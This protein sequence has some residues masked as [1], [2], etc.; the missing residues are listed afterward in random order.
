MMRLRSPAPRLPFEAGADRERG[1]QAD[2][3]IWELVLTLRRFAI[4]LISVLIEEPMIQVSP[5]S[6]LTLL[7]VLDLV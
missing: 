5:S 4:A 2:Y 3:K 7:F 1:F 6:F